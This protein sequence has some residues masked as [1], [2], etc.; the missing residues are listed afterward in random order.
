MAMMNGFLFLML[1]LCGI[2]V[3]MILQNMNMMEERAERAMRIVLTQT[4]Q[5]NLSE[6]NDTTFYK[7]NITACG[8]YMSSFMTLPAV[9]NLYSQN[10]VS[11]PQETKVNF[12]FALASIRKIEIREQANDCLFPEIVRIDICA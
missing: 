4:E 5:S 12:D 11:E 6:S 3:W 10:T 9:M 2:A 1:I 8:H 7:N